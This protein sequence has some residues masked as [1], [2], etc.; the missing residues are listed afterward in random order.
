M[1]LTCRLQPDDDALLSRERLVR[2]GDDRRNFHAD[3]QELEESLMD[4]P[5]RTPNAF[6]IGTSSTHSFDTRITDERHQVAR[7][8]VH[9]TLLFA[10]RDRVL[11][12]LCLPKR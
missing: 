6:S 4:A 12:K 9:L 11:L 5:I 7:V 8:I 3:A 1:R 10:E 2:L